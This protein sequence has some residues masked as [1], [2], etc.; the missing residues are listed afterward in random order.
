AEAPAPEQTA[1]PRP[2][3][4]TAR[5]TRPIRPA[6]AGRN[7]REPPKPTRAIRHPLRNKARFFG[8]AFHPRLK[9]ARKKGWMRCAPLLT[10]GVGRTDRKQVPAWPARGLLDGQAKE[11]GSFRYVLIRKVISERQ[12]RFDHTGRASEPRLTLRNLLVT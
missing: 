7:D 11:G 1:T 8:A 5:T 3:R 12:F 9:A 2:A 6:H 10:G 4:E